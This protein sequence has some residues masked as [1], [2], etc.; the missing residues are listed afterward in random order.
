[1]ADLL[2][3]IWIL[4][5]GPLI[6]AGILLLV[7]FIII[8]ARYGGKY[9]ECVAYAEEVVRE[10]E[11]YDF[12]MAETTYLYDSEGNQLAKLSGGADSVYLSYVDIPKDAINAFVAVEDRTFW[13]ND[14][15]D[16]KGIFRVLF[17]Y[18]FSHGDDVAGAS[19]ITQQLARTT[20]LTREVSIE[21]KVKE[22]LVA[23]RLTKR[24]SKQELMEYY[25]NSANFGNAI[26]GLE[27]AARSYFGKSAS[28]LS[29]AETA[30]LCA[31]P[32][33]P[34]YFNPYE[35]KERAVPRQQKI[36]RDM[37]EQG[38]ITSVQYERALE[39]PIQI[40]PRRTS[41]IPEYNF[42]TTYAIDCAIRYLMRLDGFSFRYS[43]ST[44]EEYREYR[45]SFDEEYELERTNLYSGGYKVYTS[46]DSDAQKRLQEVL[47]REL[48]FEI[49]RDV[50]EGIFAFQGAMTA[51]DNSNGRV[52][53]VV[54]GRSQEYL[55]ETYGLNRAYQSYRQPGSSVKP[56]AVYTPALMEGFTEDSTLTDVDVKAAEEGKP[57]LELPGQGYSLKNAVTNSRNGC[58]LY[59]FGQ[60][61][62]KK[63]LSYL[64]DMEFERILPSDYVLSSALGT[65]SVTT[66][67]MAGAYAA[68]GNN[69]TFRQ[70]TCLSSMR[71][72]NGRELFDGTEE[73]QVYDAAAADKMV[74]LMESVISEGTGKSMEWE[75]FSEMPAAGKTG[76]TNDNKDGWFCGLTPYYTLTVWV[77]FDNPRSMEGLSGG[78]YPALIWREGMLTLIRDL[79]VKE[80]S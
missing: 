26:Y 78:S 6:V 36:L 45:E 41:L 39:E 27:A 22:M 48:E 9:K 61:T 54:G 77:G 17:K 37:K 47:D 79:P 13:K 57:V 4:L 74:E 80:F 49:E 38:Y 33:R 32:N 34:T 43:F 2:H 53:A 65:L 29:L 69:G 67:Q 70:V 62:P 60:L 40:T 75:S 18:I 52:I 16:V 63:G 19:T 8:Y 71:D 76:T 42:E 23:K 28:E 51:I 66:T 68:L 56:I 30:Y 5:E 21:R 44:D 24:Y 55:S 11:P 20:Y 15:V 64:Q 58:A 7:G 31:L 46:L 73:K 50:D 59:V 35:D 25:I 1:M 12:R 3:G 72:K 14:G 10:S